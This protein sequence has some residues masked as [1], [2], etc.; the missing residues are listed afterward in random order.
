MGSTQATSTRR[1]CTLVILYPGEIVPGEFV[2]RSLVLR[3][4]GP[5][6][7]SSLDFFLW[8][9]RIAKGVQSWWL[10]SCFLR[11]AGYVTSI[12]GDRIRGQENE[13][14]LFE[15]TRPEADR[16]VES[17]KRAYEVA[18]IGINFISTIFRVMPKTEPVNTS[19]DTN[20][21]LLYRR[22]SGLIFN[23]STVLESPNDY[24]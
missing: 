9:L 4:F 20:Y 16:H 13:W 10:K 8:F 1:F 5:T 14:P 23:I 22:I 3:R 21:S 2:T 12:N 19:K 24:A 17:N 11:K 18:V 7:I 15:V 6:A